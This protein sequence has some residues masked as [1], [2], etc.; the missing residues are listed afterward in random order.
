MGI[1]TVLF[2]NLIYIFLCSQLEVYSLLLPV[3]L[4]GI[5]IVVLLA[6]SGLFSGLNLGLMSLDQTELRQGGPLASFKETVSLDFP[7][8]DLLRL[9]KICPL[10]CPSTRLSSGRGH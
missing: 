2:L 10:S 6:L 3:W 8:S 5:L 9:L 1:H 7:L 4:M